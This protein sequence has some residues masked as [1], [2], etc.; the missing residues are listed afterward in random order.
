MN[1]F[2]VDELGERICA[3]MHENP[4]PRR[5]PAK[6]S[7]RLACPEHLGMAV[8]VASILQEMTDA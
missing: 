3:Q 8:E 5:F 7:P 1:N 6:R 4:R 2:N